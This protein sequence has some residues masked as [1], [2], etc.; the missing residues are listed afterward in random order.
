MSLSIALF[1]TN[2]PSFKVFP[3]TTSC[4]F[5]TPFNL[6]HNNS[7][8]IA[9]VVDLEPQFRVRILC[10]GTVE[11]ADS[12]GFVVRILSQCSAGKS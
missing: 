8:T 6:H 12:I 2:R 10:S 5:L 4:N 1:A 3:L 7:K 9:K 11:Q